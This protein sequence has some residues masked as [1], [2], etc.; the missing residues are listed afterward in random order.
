[1]VDEQKIVVEIEGKDKLSALLEAVAEKQIR[2]SKKTARQ[3]EKDAKKQVKAVDGLRKSWSQMAQGIHSMMAIAN[4][5]SDAFGRM[6]TSAK[7]GAQSL[8]LKQALDRKTGGSAAAL[9]EQMRESVQGTASDFELLKSINL[10]QSFGIPAQKSAQLLEVAFKASVATGQDMKY[11]LDSVTTAVARKSSRV[12][13]NLGIMLK[14]SEAEAMYAK[15]LGKTTAQM[16]EAEKEASFLYGTIVKGN[17]AFAHVKDIDSHAA[18]LGK[19]EAGYRNLKDSVSEGLAIL[20]T[21]DWDTAAKNLDK[22]AHTLPMVREIYALTGRKFTGTPWEEAARKVRQFKPTIGGEAVIGKKDVAEARA[23]GFDVQEFEFEPMEVKKQSKRRGGGRSKKVRRASD[24]G[25]G[26]SEG[27][28]AFAM[29][30]PEGLDLLEHNMLRADALLKERNEMWKVANDDWLE[31]DKAFIDARKYHAE[32]AEKELLEQRKENATLAFDIMGEFSSRVA[33]QADV[34]AESVGTMIDAS[35]EE[36]TKKGIKGLGSF[37]NAGMKMLGLDSIGKMAWHTAEA[38]AAMIPPMTN[39]IKAAMHGAAA[40]G[41]AISAAKNLAG[42]FGGG[43]GGGGRGGP[44][45]G[46]VPASTALNSTDKKEE[47]GPPKTINIYLNGATM[48][49]GDAADAADVGAKL[50]GLQGEA[51]NKYGAEAA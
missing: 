27:G 50:L 9:L 16:T 5:V 33:S 26:L 39:P 22:V 38:I 21:G 18:A 11:M 13:D 25:V 6:W 35:S 8:D 47:K 24:E 36:N 37:F 31:Q 42:V 3:A 40:A 1:M 7:Q 34:L 49:G 28:V 2:L 17:D 48:I 20:V 15:H 10:M 32:F 43:S 41:H 19:V 14:V 46:G 30:D 4:R 51:I 23:A 45:M 29:G 44:K 12:L